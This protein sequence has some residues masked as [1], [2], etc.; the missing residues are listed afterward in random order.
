MRRYILMLLI[1]LM[2]PVSAEAWWNEDW[3]YRK[4]ITLDT[5]A[6]GAAIDGP[7]ENVPVLVRL[8]TG[9]FRFFLDVQPKGEDLRFL[10]ADDKTPLNFHIEKFDPINEMALLWVQVPQLPAASKSTSIWMYYGNPAAAAA[11]DAAATFDTSQA[12]IFHFDEQQPVPKDITA[13]A[14]DAGQSNA[15]VNKASLAGAGL[16]FRGESSVVVPDTPSLGFDPANGWTWSAWVKIDAEQ[17][18]AVL[19]ERSGAAGRLVLGV[20]GTALYGRFEDP[21]GGRVESPRSSRLSPGGWHHVALTLTAERMSIHI[22]GNESAYLE[23][24]FPAMQGDLVLG[25]AADG[26][27]AFTGE[28]DEIGVSGVARSADWLKAA[29][30][31]Q[32]QASRLLVYGE[33]ASRQGGDSEPSY[34]VVTLKNVT[35][36]GWAVIVVLSMM[37]AI[38]WVVMFSKGLAIARIRKDN[39]AFQ[40]KF[41]EL[42]T[43][44][45]DDLDAEESEETKQLRE[46]PLL[47]ALSGE[48]KHFESST[49]YRIYH[50]GVQEMHQRMPKAVGAQAAVALELKPQAI[51][52]IRATMDGVLTR[53]NQKLNSQM[54]LLTIAI[55]GGPFLGLLG[56]VVGVMITFAAIA[57]SGDVNVNAIAPGIAAALVATVAGLAVAIP[58]LFGYN[59]LGSRIKE[60]SADMHVFVDEFVAKIA[61]QHS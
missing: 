40:D 11:A 56:T 44:D 54:V 41:A 3:S 31:S 27:R 24:A 34:F 25:A 8:H 19:L 60:I 48:H 59:Y 30:Q 14:N 47:L 36:D 58:A 28:L 26:Q 61:E 49:L 32:G 4:Q 50:A 9:N 29:V 45:V 33:D 22:D 15:E 13:Y 12:L 38:S 10:A 6:A 5:S 43:A 57:A 20:D 37:A 46:S 21:V 35:V 39:A 53:E 2:L 23:S 17:P 18:D 55:S 52:A 42:G 16:S 51:D 1:P 7:L